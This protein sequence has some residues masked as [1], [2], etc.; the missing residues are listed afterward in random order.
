MQATVSQDNMSRKEPMQANEIKY[1]ALNDW[2]LQH[3]VNS[4]KPEKYAH[5]DSLIERFL[6]N[7]AMDNMTR[8]LYRRKNNLDYTVIQL[9]MRIPK[10][11]EYI[12][13]LHKIYA[14]AKAKE[15]LYVGHQVEDVRMDF[16]HEP[17]FHNFPD[18]FNLIDI[19]A[20]YQE[21]VGIYIELPEYKREQRYRLHFVRVEIE[22]FYTRNTP[23]FARDLQS[24]YYEYAFTEAY[25]GTFDPDKNYSGYMMYP[26]HLSGKQVDEKIADMRDRIDSYLQGLGYE[27]EIFM[28]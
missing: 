25:R 28:A 2:D 16:L 9:Y 4:L 3:L 26:K 10:L 14:E 22:F 18:M 7:R 5:L 12:K 24:Q 13:K 6:E 19:F 20:Y 11:R 17:E 21:P 15:R 8:G 23:Y 1:H 27:T